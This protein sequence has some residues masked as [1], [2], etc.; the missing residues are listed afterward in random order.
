[1]ERGRGKVADGLREIMTVNYSIH[2]APST[3]RGVDL[4]INKI[5]IWRFPT[6]HHAESCITKLITAL[7]DINFQEVQAKGKKKL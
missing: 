7:P 1:M 5:L 3:I 6:M 2:A 4:T